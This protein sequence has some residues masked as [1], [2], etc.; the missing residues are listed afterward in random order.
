MFETEFSI[1][2]LE[3]ILL[4]FVRI[5]SMVYLVP[6]LGSTGVP[7]KVKIGFSA[8]L[9]ILLATIIPYEPLPYTSIFE[10]S[11]LVIKEVIIGLLIGFFMNICMTILAFAGQMIDME[12]G[13]TMV[14]MFDPFNKTQ[15]TISASL[16]NILVLL[17]V[18]VSELYYFIIDAIVNSFKYVPVGVNIYKLDAIYDIFVR[19]MKDFFV[20]GFQIAMPVF[21]AALLL[22]VILGV[23]AKAAPQMNMFV[24]G[25]QLKVFLGFGVLLVTIG[26]LPNITEFIF[27]EIKILVELLYG[28]MS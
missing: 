12:I 7:N 27:K 19:F 24:V 10:Y 3:F 6:V 23:L 28:A 8:M 5:A 4:I 15:T 1:Y 18:V 9:A 2:H 17:I 21:A 22:N 20:I 13:F 26:F 14:S 25:I 16:Y 11:G